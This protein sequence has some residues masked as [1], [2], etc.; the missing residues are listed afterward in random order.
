[1]LQRRIRRLRPKC[2]REVV[3]HAVQRRLQ[4]RPTVDLRH[5]KLPCLLLGPAL[6]LPV[7][8]RS[9]LHRERSRSDVLLRQE[10]QAKLLQNAE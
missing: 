4:L 7:Q 6:R 8:R 2:G 1:M 5:A 10:M 3:V 9:P